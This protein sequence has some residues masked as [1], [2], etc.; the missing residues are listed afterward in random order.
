[1][2][3]K[4]NW[5][6]RRTVHLLMLLCA[7]GILCSAFVLFSDNREYAHGNA[8]YRRIRRARAQAETAADRADP[9][10]G[11]PKQEPDTQADA[12]GRTESADFTALEK[13][14]PDV[15]A[16]L[17]AEGTPIDYPVVQGRDNDYYLRH[18]FTGEQNKL[19]SLFLDYRSDRD[20]SDQNTVIY[21]HNMKDG[22]MFSSLEKYK[23]QR[24]Y[25]SF[26]TMALDT[27]GGSFTVE[28]FAGIVADG[29]YESVRFTFQDGQ[30]FLRY[31]DS[32]K[33][34]STFQSG[35][36]VEQGDRIVTFCTCTYEFQNA[37]YVLFGKL[38]PR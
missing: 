13:L 18:L 30:D 32:V 34:A 36:T 14:N 17:T 4:K 24:Y 1:M 28:L 11:D 10:A 22:S 2:H 29:T 3:H 21:G 26:P 6:P 25:D 15:A 20:F 38:T 5:T 23:E 27:P 16:W 12:D 8:A 19:G 35:V 9:P 33:R 7:L 37:R 31:V